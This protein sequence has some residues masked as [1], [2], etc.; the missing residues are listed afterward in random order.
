MKQNNMLAMILAGGRGTRLHE[1]TKKMAKPAV[2]Y[3]GKYRIIEELNRAFPTEIDTF[4]DLF[5]GGANVAVNVKARKYV[6]NDSERALID[7]LRYL[8]DTPV[9]III[10][11]VESIIVDFNLSQSDIHGYEYYLSNSSQGLAFYNREAFLKLRKAYNEMPKD[12]IKRS[13]Y[14][15]VLI[16]YSFNNQIRFN[17]NGDFNLPVGKRDFN[18]RLKGK[19]VSFCSRL[20]NMDVMFSSKDFRELDIPSNTFVYADPPYLITNATYNER[21]GW[22]EKDELDLLSFLEDFD[23]KGGQ[24]ALSN[25]LVSRNR[26]NTI[27]KK[28]LESHPKFKVIHIDRSYANSNYHIK[29]KKA[30]SDEIL[31]I[32]Y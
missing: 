14:L 21:N 30:I 13:L 22:S 18:S 15:F 11:D 26:E 12:D 9:D 32:N 31:V 8:H 25:I 17:N 5:A 1:L 23:E 27:L 29:D 16:T 19:L 2:S 7:L 28:W 3:G 20:K 6:I 4:M 10:K 24:F